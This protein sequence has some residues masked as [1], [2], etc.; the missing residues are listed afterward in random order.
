VRDAE[1]VRAGFAAI[2]ENAKAANPAAR[3]RGVQAQKMIAG[4]HEVIIGM[5]RDPTFGPLMVFGL[6]GI[7]VEALHDV[8][9]RLAPLSP[10]EA[11]EMIDASRV[12]RLLAGLRGQPPSDRAALLDA[13][14]RAGRMA[15][16]HPEISE[17]DLNPVV[18]LEAG[19]GVYALDARVVLAGMGRVAIGALRDE[20]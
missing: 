8:V 9:H 17:L 19:Q 2:L 4:G 14:V 18:V 13:L 11:A 3:I 1:G 5:K 12:A 7:Y 10:V 20:T 6:G 16:E 15:A